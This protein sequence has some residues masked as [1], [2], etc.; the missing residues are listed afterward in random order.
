M[1]KTSCHLKWLNLLLVVLLVACSSGTIVKTYE[2]DALSEGKIAVLTASKNINLISVNGKRVKK[3]LMRS[4]EVK[5]G[6]Q[7]GKNLVVF[8]YGSVWGTPTLGDED[9]PRAKELMS[10]QREVLIDA[11]A[12]DRLAFRYGSAN[13]IREAEVLVSNFEAEILD[14]NGGVVAVSGEPGIYQQ[15]PDVTVASRGLVEPTSGSL[16]GQ[17]TKSV[18]VDSSLPTIDAMKVLWGTASSDEKQAFLKWAF[19]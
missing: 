1:K 17:K 8:Q 18:S 6:L 5:Y 3:Y 4:L 19:Q 7:P 13:N 16:S 11:K 2:G 14:Q 15:A 10:A 12:G 9:A